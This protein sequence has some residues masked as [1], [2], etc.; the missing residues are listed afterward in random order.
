MG[1][2][3]ARVW[4]TKKVGL[5]G[6]HGEERGR[7]PLGESGKGVRGTPGSAPHP[8]SL[9][10]ARLPHLGGGSVS[11]AAARVCEGRR[12]DTGAGPRGCKSR[13]GPGHPRGPCA[14]SHVG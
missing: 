6:Y 7:F 14:A 2:V 8:S 10:A 11:G 9:P 4:E 12:E 13:E 3:A 1:Q 5:G